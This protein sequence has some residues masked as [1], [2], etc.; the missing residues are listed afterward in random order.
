MW[1]LNDINRRR[2][3]QLVIHTKKY[4]KMVLVIANLKV[5]LM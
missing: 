1:K 4:P 3:F 2:M 5:S